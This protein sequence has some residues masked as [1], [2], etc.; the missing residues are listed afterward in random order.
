MN[1]LAQNTAFPAKRQSPSCFALNTWRLLWCDP[2]VGN[3]SASPSVRFFCSSS[4]LVLKSTFHRETDSGTV[5]LRCYHGVLAQ[6]V[7]E[8]FTGQS[9]RE[10]FAHPEFEAS[11]SE[12]LTLRKV[13]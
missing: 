3:A 4:K 5:D 9:L 13:P 10:G 1:R 7:H 8:L 6:I 11:K 2:I 12:S